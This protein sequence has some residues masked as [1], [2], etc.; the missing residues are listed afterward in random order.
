M[1]RFRFRTN[2][3]MAIANINKMKRFFLYSKELEVASKKLLEQIK[4]VVAIKMKDDTYSK[5]N[6]QATNRGFGFHIDRITAAI[7]TR[8]LRNKLSL[9]GGVGEITKL[10][11][12]DP[13][14][15][16]KNPPRVL[17]PEVR[18]WRILEYGTIKKDYLIKAK[19]VS[20][21][22]A[23]K[24]IKNSNKVSITTTKDKKPKALPSSQ[25]VPQL[26][27]FWKKANVPFR[28]PVVEHPGQIGRGVWAAVLDYEVRAIYGEGMKEEMRQIVKRYSGR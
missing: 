1:F 20:Q 9:V 13:L 27:F 2:P 6:P 12:A 8:V 14:L 23:S 26:R 11:A 22:P 7:N 17:T 3:K 24:K 21:K 15:T 16:L 5:R 18:L 25:Q 10:D 19:N 28:G 4:Q